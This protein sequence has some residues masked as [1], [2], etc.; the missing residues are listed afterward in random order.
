MT[1]KLIYMSRSKSEIPQQ[2]LISEKLGSVSILTS[3]VKN[4][5]AVLV[6]AHGAGAAMHHPFM[7]AVAKELEHHAIITVRYNFLYMEKKTKRPDPPAIAEKTVEM[8]MNFAH[9]AFPDL[10]VF[11]GGK[12][13][14]GR[15]SSQRL[16]K[17][18]P[19]F[20]KGLVVLGFPLHAPGKPG[21]DRASHLTDVNIPML[22]LQGTRDA[23]ATMELMEGV[24]SKLPTATLIKFEGADH[25]FKAG[26]VNLIP[27]LT[28]SIVS[29]ISD[30]LK[31]K[32]K[33]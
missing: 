15:M 22:F 13:F 32:K 31:S 26:K 9:S 4:P 6:L 10:P 21:D 28:S 14:G 27:A 29:W 1:D 33:K 16:S 5:I 11:V 2:V 24:C 18:T 17:E 19:D 8:M 20:V 30:V 25:S 3:Q 7:E 23:L 12:S